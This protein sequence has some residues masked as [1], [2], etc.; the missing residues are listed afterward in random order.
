M[1]CGNLSAAEEVAMPM[2]WTAAPLTAPPVAA[3]PVVAPPSSG[4]VEPAQHESGP[5]ADYAA[6]QLPPE[7][8]SV[9]Y[10]TMEEVESRIHDLAWT[11]GGFKITPYGI[12]WGSAVYQTNRTFP[13][14]YTLFVSPLNKEGEGAFDIDTR[15]TRLGVDIIGPRLPG[16]G[17]AIT[18]G[19]I[20]IDFFGA[21]VAQNKPGVL[22]RHAYGEIK[23]EEFR[24]LAGQTWDVISP[25][26]PG[27][28]SY[29]VMWDQ[30]NIGYRRAQIRGERYL[31]LPSDQ[32]LTLQLSANQDINGDFLTE[33]GVE[34]ETSDWPVLEGRVAITNETPAWLAG[35]V[36]LGVSGHI[37]EQGWDF[38]AVGPPPLLLPAADDVRIRTW[39][40]NV[41]LRA[42]L[43]KRSGIQGEYF[44]GE[45][46][47]TF[48][49]G[50]GQGV[51]PC[52][53]EPIRAHGGWVEYW[54][55]WS[56][57]YHSHFGYGVDDPNDNDMLV[58]RT[59]NQ[60]IFANIVH[61]VTKFIVIGF[62]V[63][64]AKTNHEENRPGFVVP[65][66]GDSVGFEF[67]GQYI[68]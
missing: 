34:P 10:L 44:M 22:L 23:N 12:L 50:I 6:M 54:Y 4:R 8:E 45:N 39:S 15:R 14:P 51:C 33:P 65:E 16:C 68:F 47:S 31:E 55:D 30:G 27:T 17:N 3:S 26:N 21:F 48:F 13:G 1:L 20:E 43:T 25:L 57:C 38:T 35:P 62:E 9:D 49:G 7:E 63:S 40:C 53:R 24:V 36:T 28:L 42:P 56:P 58:G 52:L 32:L 19:K 29:S 61:D 41:D 5:V 2:T 46:L 18:G 60:N 11:K 59:Y 67:A 66:S 37:G 64:F